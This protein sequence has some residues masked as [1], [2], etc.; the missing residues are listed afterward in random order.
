VLEKLAN[1]FRIPFN[2]ITPGKCLGSNKDYILKE[3]FLLAKLTSNTRKKMI[4]GN[5]ILQI[6]ANDCISFNALSWFYSSFLIS[7][8]IIFILLIY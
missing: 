6:L 7:F 8:L 1:G 4:R 3:N 5:D 2:R